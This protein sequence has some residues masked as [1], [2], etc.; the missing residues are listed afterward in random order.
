LKYKVKRAAEA[1]MSEETSING[2]DT[3]VGSLD[4]GATMG[5]AEAAAIMRDQTERTEQA[6][7]ISH[8]GSFVTWGL[9]ILLGYGVT[10]LYIRNQQ[11][12]R[13]PQPAAFAVVS[14]LAL[15]SALASGAEARRDAGV[16]GVSARRRRIHLLSLLVGLGAMYGLE[17]ALYRAGAGRPVLLVFEATAPIVVAALFFLTSGALWLDWPLVAFGLWL[18]VAAVGGA[19]AGPAGVWGVDALA[20]GLAYLFMAALEPLLRRTSGLRLRQS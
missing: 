19:L 7:R 8:R 12:I 16:G 6:F 20:V 18:A 4:Q 17:G 15:G 5:A 10:W 13:G 14:L 3:S 9:I 1:E 11:P 2:T